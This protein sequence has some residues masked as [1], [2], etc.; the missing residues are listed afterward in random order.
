MSTEESQEINLKE[1]LTISLPDLI[2]IFKKSLFLI[3]SITALFS[4]ISIFY[5]LS[6]EKYYRSTLLM[7]PA[8]GIS[9]SSGQGLGALL[10][11]ITGSSSSMNSGINSEEALAILKSRSFIE[12]FVEEKNY[13]T[14]IF[15]TSWD[16]ES[17][18]WKT[19]EPPTLLD[20]Y[21]F[22]SDNLKI[23]F[24]KSLITLSIDMNKAELSS[25]LLNDMISKVNSHIKDRSIED[26]NKSIFFLDS[27]IRK[28]NLAAS[29]LMLYGLIEQQTQII[30]LANTR[31]EYAF[32]VIDPAVR[33]I[34]P[35][36]PNRKVIVILITFMGF[37]FA[38]LLALVIN[39]KYKN[40]I[41]RK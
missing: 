29:K 27:E 3:I 39:S 41:A 16:E 21:E 15:N 33:P 28:T 35:A 36:G 32:K 40:L 14:T 38:L 2:N 25:S 34:H 22:I 20:S 9:Q 10:G 11:G 4:I 7:V 17:L 19:D 30:M 37:S 8:E 6:L 23:T 5:S 13:L 1:A 12:S 18:E 26:G 31:D 24:D